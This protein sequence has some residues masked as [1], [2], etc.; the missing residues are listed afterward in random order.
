MNA[1]LVIPTVAAAW[2]VGV[3][4]T[5]IV[6]V[7]FSPYTHGNLAAAYEPGY[8]RTAQIVVGP[9]IPYEGMGLDGRVA[10]AADPAARGA[11]LMVDK[12]CATCHGLDGK[13]TSV[14]VSLTGLSAAILRSTTTMG[15]HGM[16]AFAPSS[17]SDDDL[18][19]IAAYVNAKK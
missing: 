15:P 9:A 12:G 5:L 18:A 10:L 1:K 7:V 8:E 3:G 11:E 17:L 4:A 14:G 2:V 13:G 16:P 6:I 19:A